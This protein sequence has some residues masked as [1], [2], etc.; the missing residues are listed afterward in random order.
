MDVKRIL[1]TSHLQVLCA[2]LEFEIIES[3]D[4]KMQ[5]I[6]TLQSTERGKRMYAAL[7]ERQIQLRE[8]VRGPTLITLQFPYFT[9]MCSNKKVGLV[10]SLY[11]QSQRTQ[12]WQRCS[13]QAPLAIWNV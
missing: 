4:L 2:V 12:T 10:S 13:A 1:I 3:A 7:C 8:L 6:T 11:H 9:F 5:M